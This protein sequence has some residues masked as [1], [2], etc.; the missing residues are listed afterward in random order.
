MKFKVLMSILLAG[1]LLWAQNN[2]LDFDGTDDEVSMSLIDFTSTDKISISAWVKPDNVNSLQNVVE[3]GDANGHALWLNANGGFFAGSVFATSGWDIV[4]SGNSILAQ[5]KWQHIAYTYD[6]TNQKIYLN[7]VEVGTNSIAEEFAASPTGD[8]GISEESGPFSGTIDEVRFWNDARTETEIRQ[9]MYQ[10]LSNPAGETNLVA[11]YKFNETSGTSSADSKGSNTGTLTNMAG[12]E[13]TTS[14]AIF[15]PKNCLNFDGTDDYIL[16]PNLTETSSGTIEMWISPE[17]T[18]AE[19]PIYGNG[20]VG[21]LS[22][23]LRVTSSYELRFS[24]HDG[25]W[26]EINSN[27][28]TISTTGWTH[29]AATWNGSTGSVYVNGVF[30]KSGNCSTITTFV[31]N[32]NLGG[33]TILG[34]MDYFSGKIDEFRVWDDLRSETEIRENMCKTLTGNESNLVAYY[35]FDNATGTT[36]QDF[37]GNGNDGTLTNMA[38]DDWVASA[39]FNTWLN[40]TSTSWATASNWSRGIVPGSSDNTGIYSYSGGSE[41]ALAGSTFVKIIYLAPSSSLTLN[42]GITITE[43][44]ILDN[45]LDL[46]GQTVA[47]GNGKLLV[48]GNGRIIGSS[49]K[50]RMANNT[51]APLS[52]ENFGGLGAEITTAIDPV[53]LTVERGHAAQTGGGNNSILRYYDITPSTNT[54]LNATLVFHYE[55]AELNGLTEANLDL[56]KSTDGGSTWTNMGGTVNTTDNTVTLAGID[57]FSRWTLGGSGDQSL[58]VTLLS[59]SAAN[60]H[61][62]VILEWETASEIDNRGFILRRQVEAANIESTV[63]RQS[64]S[65]KIA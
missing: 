43:M 35:N 3:I 59:F 9:N 52:S 12:S 1:S 14:S 46:N 13:W 4:T 55:D 2:A 54:G 15:G 7:G 51:S 32:C 34:S 31:G 39:A 21:S 37:S 41:P 11:Y 64:N 22:M 56:Y 50:I 28:N 36:L 57:G 29:I 18:G 19:N 24:V 58:P 25:S 61:N 23:A 30:Q 44:L 5:N 47:L 49:G 8:S 16:M 17:A 10:E 65:D 45:N 40:S 42:A 26:H 48:E 63:S 20:P 27:V 53:S 38:N 62:G 60:S 33:S 6:G